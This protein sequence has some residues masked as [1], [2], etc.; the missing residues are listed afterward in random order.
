MLTLLQLLQ[1]YLSLFLD[2]EKQFDEISKRFL[3]I[4]N[5]FNL[6]KLKPDA[7]LT[8]YLTLAQGNIVNKNTDK[9][10]EYLENYTRIVTG[11]IYPLKLKGDDFFTL[12][13]K[14]FE[15]F[16]IGTNPPRDEKVIKQSMYEAVANNPQFSVF[17]DNIQFE[18]I[19]RKLKNNC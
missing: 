10:L 1:S 15:S 9:A 4:A 6:D 16:P 14:W 3:A 2:D 5:I 13:D 12:I 19:V 11:N 7:L 17:E 18:N 8:F